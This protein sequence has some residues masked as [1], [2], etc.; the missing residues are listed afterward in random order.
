[1]LRIIL[2]FCCLL[3]SLAHAFADD[4]CFNMDTSKMF[5]CVELEQGCNP[6]NTTKVCKT[7]TALYTVESAS[8]AKYP[9][10]MVHMDATFYIAQAVG[11]HYDA[12]HRIAAYDQAID[13]GDY[14]PVDMRGNP[15]VDPALC[16][17]NKQPTGCKFFAKPLN[18][19]VRMSLGTGGT[20]FHYGSLNNPKNAPVNGLNPLLNDP[21]IE[22]MITNLRAWIFM[23][24]FL[25]TAGLNGFQVGTC[26]LKSNGMP[27][28]IYGIIPTL[29]HDDRADVQFKIVIEEQVLHQDT[30][31]TVYASDLAS[32]VGTTEA[33]DVKM[34]IYLHTLQDRISHHKCMDHTSLSAPNMT[35]GENFVA[36][37]PR[38]ACHQSIHLI[39]HGWETGIEQSKV[40]VADRTLYP[41]L[42]LTYDELLLYAQRHGWARPHAT[43]KNYKKKVLEAIQTSLQL[44]TPEKRLAALMQ[45]MDSFG[46]KRL[47]GH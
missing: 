44:P 29:E 37:Y 35:P 14:I 28:Q 36:N 5:N 15:I 6:P 32:Y 22:T 16:V 1:M 47:P 19:L 4:I 10:S 43:D 38:D 11:I 7:Q 41:S 25:C 20:F 24:N 33:S 42:D 45:A 12:A 31:M 8:L 34:G 3:P 18:G 27:G 23:D 46:F 40:P 39:W 26:Y 9:R 21:L 17:G 2:L 13:L 30:N